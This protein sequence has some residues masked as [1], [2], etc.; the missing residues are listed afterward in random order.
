MTL[1]RPKKA[2][3]RSTRHPCSWM[4]FLAVGSVLLSATS[5]NAEGRSS[6]S[7]GESTELLGS[8]V[9]VH[10]L[11][12]A[13]GERGFAAVTYK[14]GRR[15]FGGTTPGKSARIYGFVRPA[16]SGSFGPRKLVARGAREDPL[17]EGGG[18]G[19]AVLAWITHRNRLMAS[20]VRANGQWTSPQ[21]LTRRPPRLVG[22]LDLDV[23]ADGSAVLS[24]IENFGTPQMKNRIAVKKAASEKFSHPRTVARGTGK[25]GAFVAVAAR[26]GGRGIVAWSRSCKTSSEGVETPLTTYRSLHHLQ[27]K[28][29]KL[30]KAKTIPGSACPHT[31]LDIAVNSRGDAVLLLSGRRNE[32]SVRLSRMKPGGQFGRSHR[33]S[34]SGRNISF[35]DVTLDRAG[36]AVIA[37]LES[38]KSG[39]PIGPVLAYSL[40][41]KRSAFGELVG[42]APGYYLRGSL[43]GNASGDFGLVGEDLAAFELAGWLKTRREP[44][45]QTHIAGPLSPQSIPEVATS[46]SPSGRFSIL[47]SGRVDRTN[48]SGLTLTT[49]REAR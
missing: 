32:F 23:A 14:E 42:R 13:T 1:T 43:D 34:G 18:A 37:A 49:I 44:L 16:G 27:K 29:T 5:A 35:A 8:E 33:I 31:N 21:A 11:G 30:S 40:R 7:T 46:M 47:N 2:V 15:Q 36:K 41:G 45:S 39:S 3:L 20:A 22:G 17:L 4:I 28:A 10:A 48:D 24:W 12:L 19:S 9:Q 26:P 25:A 6:S 38:N